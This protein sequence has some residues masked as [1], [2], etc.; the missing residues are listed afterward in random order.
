MGN[1]VLIGLWQL[2]ATTPTPAPVSGS[3]TWDLMRVWV[4]PPP[5]PDKPGLSPKLTGQFGKKGFVT[6]EG[7]GLLHPGG[8]VVR[9]DL[10]EGEPRSYLCLLWL[11]L[12]LWHMF[13]HGPGTSACYR[14]SQN[15][16][17]INK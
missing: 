15:N 8:G 10:G 13:H 4:L 3:S 14:H 7:S 17:I 12:L 6:K 5:R 16:I 1:T 9:G 11:R 2:P